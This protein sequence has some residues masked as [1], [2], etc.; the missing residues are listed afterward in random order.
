[1]I[2][3]V[4]DGEQLAASAAGTVV[5][6]QEIGDA[7]AVQLV[8]SEHGFDDYDVTG[9]EVHRVTIP[10]G[11]KHNEMFNVYGPGS[12]KR[13]GT[14]QGT[15]EASIKE[16]LSSIPSSAA[17]RYIMKELDAGNDQWAVFDRKDNTYWSHDGWQQPDAGLA[18]VLSREE[19]L[20]MVDEL[21]S[22]GQLKKFLVPT[23]VVVEAESAEAADDLVGNMQLNYLG[24]GLIL[25]LDETLPTVQVDASA[26]RE[27]FTV[28]DEPEVLEAAKSFKP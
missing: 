15:V 27:F 19:A 17:A 21:S 14:W 22:H 16:F 25:H 8:S 11:I 26:D 12:A 18:S 24:K 3:K 1:M 28:L 5:Q 4:N 20:T 13:G 2:V 9:C 23:F 7:I 10:H 6:A